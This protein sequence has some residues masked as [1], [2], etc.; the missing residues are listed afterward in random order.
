MSVIENGSGTRD[1][2][3]RVGFDGVVPSVGAALHRPT[4][5]YREI[6]E[7]FGDFHVLERFRNVIIGVSFARFDRATTGTLS[8]DE[9]HL[10]VG[11]KLFDPGQ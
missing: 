8:R 9:Q 6:A 11:V 3:V 4:A 7:S 10:G 5:L 1:K 2:W